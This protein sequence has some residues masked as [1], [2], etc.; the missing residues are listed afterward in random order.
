[1]LPECRLLERADDGTHAAIHLTDLLGPCFTALH[2]GDETAQDDAWRNCNARLQTGV[3][4][5]RQ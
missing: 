1:M 4:R 3:S 5:S 2:F